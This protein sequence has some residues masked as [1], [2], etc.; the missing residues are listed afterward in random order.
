[1]KMIACLIGLPLLVASPVLAQS[2]TPGP[3]C[4][5]SAAEIANNKRI[6]ASFFAPGM[7]AE[8]RIALMDPGYIQHNPFYLKQAKDKGI[9]EIQSFRE[10]QSAPPP[11]PAPGPRSPAPNNAYLIIAECDMV[12]IIRETWRQDPTAP[13][14][15][16]YAAYPYDTWRLRNGKLLE[17]WDAN[18]IPPPAAR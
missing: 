7:D 3:N 8:K 16:W 6:A 13:P 1:M 2:P 15:T 12:T 11:P 4:T 17:H 5:Q 18:L 10:I 9:S 14:G